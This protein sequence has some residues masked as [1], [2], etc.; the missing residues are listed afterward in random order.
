MKERN[1]SVS[2]REIKG[3]FNPLKFRKSQE[4]REINS[5]IIVNHGGVT[6]K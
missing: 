3:E 5:L 6:M 1:C 2:I 4:I